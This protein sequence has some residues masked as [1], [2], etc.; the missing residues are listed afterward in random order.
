MLSLFRF[1]F[2]FNKSIGDEQT[3]TYTHEDKTML[4]QLNEW[5]I[6]PAIRRIK[7]NLIDVLKITD[8]MFMLAAQW[9]I[10]D[11]IYEIPPKLPITMHNWQNNA[12]RN[13]WAFYVCAHDRA[14]EREESSAA[15]ASIEQWNGK[16][17]CK[18]FRKMHSNENS[19]E[20]PHTVQSWT[21]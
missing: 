10:E 19:L 4:T 16:T 8:H 21:E 9:N 13:A 1:W 6:Q 14:M 3:H 7:C 11:G 15:H 17:K 5:Q 2:L 12:E 18:Q 20:P